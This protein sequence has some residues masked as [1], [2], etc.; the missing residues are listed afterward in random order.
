ADR[1][2]EKKAH[3]K[4]P[5]LQKY[6]QEHKEEMKEKIYA[7]REKRKAAEKAQKGD[8]EQITLDLTLNQD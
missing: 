6:Y 4:R 5:Y 1:I 7:A 3:P 8:P 2:A